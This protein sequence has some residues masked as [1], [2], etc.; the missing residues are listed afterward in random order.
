MPIKTL[1]PH[2]PFVILWVVVPLGLTRGPGYSSGYYVGILQCSNIKGLGCFLT[3]QYIN[4]PYPTSSGY[5]DYYYSGSADSGSNYYFLEDCNGCNGNT[6]NTIY[7]QNGGSNYFP[8]MPPDQ[9]NNQIYSQ[10]WS[11]LVI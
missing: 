1:F 8:F 6:G 2:H 7:G 9:Q 10:L 5:Y 3:T 11:I 4:N